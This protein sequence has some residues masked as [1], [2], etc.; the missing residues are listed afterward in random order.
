MENGNRLEQQFNQLGFRV[1]L[2]DEIKSPQCITYYFDCLNIAD[3]SKARVERL[4]E[5]ISAYNHIKFSYVATDKSHFAITHGLIQRQPL[6]L[7]SFQFKPNY[8]K[9][10]LPIGKDLNNNVVELDLDKIPHI[11]IAGTTGSGKSV[12]I[13][14]LI[15]SL[16]ITTPKELFE[17]TLIDP[18]KVE[19]GRFKVL[20]NVRFIDET[21]EAVAVLSEL[22]DEMEWRYNIMEEKGVKNGKGLFKTKIV[23]IDELAD[24][25]LSSRYEVEE[26]IVRLAQKSR[27][28]NIHLIIATQRPTI[29]VVSGL[30]KA[31]LPCKICL[32]V[33]SVRDSIVVLDK[34]GAE[35]LL[36]FGDCLIK[37]PYQVEE[38]RCQVA[39][40]SDERID[41]VIKTRG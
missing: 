15:S 6:F 2:V 23:I 9:I 5:K 30:I 37:L 13:N 4:L 26:S 38:T 8:D 31:N 20:P 11:L 24:L 25:M 7:S 36:G 16:Y 33:A 21:N 34:G 35:K 22:V 32:K 27:A 12:L 39:Y 1:R 28:C 17:L 3:F 41:D 18:K 10:V 29:N 40:I 19:L 14:T